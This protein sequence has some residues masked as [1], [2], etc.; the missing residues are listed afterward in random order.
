MRM[1]RDLGRMENSNGNR[2]THALFFCEACGCEVIRQK[3]SGLKSKT[4]GC[5]HFKDAGGKRGGAVPKADRIDYAEAGRLYLGG[6]STTQVGEILG[7]SSNTVLKALRAVGVKTRSISEARSLRSRGNRR[8][9]Q[10]GYVQLRVNHGVRKKEHVHIAEQAIGRKL[11]RG[12]VV[13]HINGDRSDNRNC[14]LLICTI[15]YHTW[16]H[17]KMTQ[18]QRKEM[19][20]EYAKPTVG[21]DNTEQYQRRFDG[22]PVF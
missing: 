9:D 10:H 18:I 13:H 21:L 7:V 2:R 3:G 14:N 15:Q 5:V 17:W 8:I 22:Q 11:K 20:N 19:S 12:E 6:L 4:C 1:I 16:L